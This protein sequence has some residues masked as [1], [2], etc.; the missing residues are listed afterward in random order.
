MAH[1]IVTLTA[2]Q[3][4][5]IRKSLPKKDDI[6]GY[7]LDCEIPSGDWQRGEGLHKE[8][9][10]EAQIILELSERHIAHEDR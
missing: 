7:L 8:F 9:R 6:Q 5:A 1:K 4:W 2:Q 10:A 3:K